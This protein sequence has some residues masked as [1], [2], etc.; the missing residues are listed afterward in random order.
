[1]LVRILQNTL[2]YIENVQEKSEPNVVKIKLISAFCECR[3]I[4]INILCLSDLELDAL[5][6]RLCRSQKAK[7]RA[8]Y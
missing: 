8:I 7:I 3:D 5:S 4:N 6:H 1:M 2:K